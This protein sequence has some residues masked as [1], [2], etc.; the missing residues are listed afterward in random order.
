[1][2][3]AVLAITWCSL[4]NQTRVVADVVSAAQSAQ[5]GSSPH[6]NTFELVFD[7]R[8]KGYRYWPLPLTGLGFLALGIVWIRLQRRSQP[9]FVTWR[10]TPYLVTGV[11]VIRTTGMLL[12][13]YTGH[14]RLVKALE[15]GHFD[16]VEG[17][18]EHFAAEDD[19]PAADTAGRRRRPK[20]VTICH[21]AVTPRLEKWYARGDS[22]SRPSAPEADALSS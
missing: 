12:I 21:T 16:T 13:T 14:S 10:L 4:T 19:A 3:L 20:C 7:V 8:E 18:V 2:T 15:S 22:N 5:V 11:S 6:G 17:T 9:Q 1:M